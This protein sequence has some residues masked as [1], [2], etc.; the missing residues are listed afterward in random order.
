VTQI[1]I[2]VVDREREITAFLERFLTKKGH[3]VRAV[4]DA[5]TAIQV[6]DGPPFDVILLD[7]SIPPVA[8]LDLIQSLQVNASDTPLIIMTTHPSVKE[9]LEPLGLNVVAYLHKPF[10]LAEL[11]RA[12]AS[13]STN[14]RSKQAMP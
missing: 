7:L 13:L 12:I 4:N 14:S 6:L 9:T 1:S 2:L 8:G 11:S 3:C 5:A 10:T